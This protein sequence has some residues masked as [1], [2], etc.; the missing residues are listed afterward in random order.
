MVWAGLRATHT[1]GPFFFHVSVTGQV[2]HDMLSEWLVPQLQQAG[3]KHTVVLQLDGA[4]PHFALHM[5]D[6]L[7]ETFPRRWIG[8]GSEASPTPFAW[9]PK[10]SRSDNARK[11]STGYCTTEVLW[12]AVEEAFTHVAPDYLRK[13]SARTW[14]RIQLCYDNEGLHTDV[15]NSYAIRHAPIPSTQP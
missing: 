2:Y 14:R 11:C 3:I 4:P 12:A 13:T 5:H 7:N 8:K 10:K 6:Y 9:H 1:F 15:L